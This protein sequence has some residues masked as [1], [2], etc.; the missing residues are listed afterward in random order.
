[1]PGWIGSKRMDRL[2]SKKIEAH[3]RY[4]LM[5]DGIQSEPVTYCGVDRYPV[6]PHWDRANLQA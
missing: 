2:T 1:M 5:P 3:H 4:Q 6:Q